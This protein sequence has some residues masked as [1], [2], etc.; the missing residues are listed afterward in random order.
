MTTIHLSW[1]K[2]KNG[3]FQ[4]FG[5]YAGDDDRFVFD[6][7]EFQTREAAEQRARRM[8]DLHAADHFARS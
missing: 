4:V 6:V 5:S 2:T 3:T 1:P 8:M 7:R